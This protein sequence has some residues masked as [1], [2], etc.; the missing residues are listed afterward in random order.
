MKMHL[1]ILT[2]SQRTQTSTAG[3]GG[4]QGE[5][6]LLWCHFTIETQLG[7]AKHW[8]FCD[9]QITL[10]FL[11][12]LLFWQLQ[13]TPFQQLDKLSKSCYINIFFHVQQFYKFSYLGCTGAT[14]EITAS[15]YKVLYK[16]IDQKLQPEVN[17]TG[18]ETLRGIILD[19]SETE[20][21]TP[22]EW[23]YIV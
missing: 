11:S 3:Q 21:V 22:L 15:F 10:Y 9:Q 6:L 2:G 18:K 14:N 7:A 13:T 4:E 8:T 1:T 23:V 17:K 12:R 5:L 16:I 19:P 20:D